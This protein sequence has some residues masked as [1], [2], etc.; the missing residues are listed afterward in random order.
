MFK[1]KLFLASVLCVAFFSSG[2]WGLI[3]S[4]NP[5]TFGRNHGKVSVGVVILDLL[6][7]P[8]CIGIVIDACAGTLREYDPGYRYRDSAIPNKI[9]F[10]ISPTDIAAH[11]DK[12]IQ[13]IWRSADG[14][15]QELYSGLV[16]DAVGTEVSVSGSGPGKLEMVVGGQI[17]ASLAVRVAREQVCVARR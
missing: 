2:C 12:R 9:R 5:S 7:S 8:F 11:G 1:R 13:V 10:R 4:Q 14:S 17:R 15:M 16:R 3:L 6:L